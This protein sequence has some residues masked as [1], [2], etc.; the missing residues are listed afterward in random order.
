[1]TPRLG[2]S[3]R[4]PPRSARLGFALLALAA[5]APLACNPTSSSTG[6]AP[7]PTAL[8]IQAGA[9]GSGPNKAITMVPG[10]TVRIAYA[11]TDAFGNQVG[12]QPTFISRDLRIALVSTRGLI[13][14]NIPG[15]TYVAAFV[16]LTSTTYLGD[17]VKVTVSGGCTL[18]AKAGLVI[19]VQDSLTGSMG[20]FT[21][22]SYVA[23]DTS[24]YKDS[25]MIATV[26]A[27]VSGNTFLVG[28]AYEHPG[29]YDVT[30][31]AAG[32]RPWIKSGVVIATDTC[33]VIPVSLTARLVPQ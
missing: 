16:G 33:H 19:S 11:L 20:P 5:L 26:P 23:H 29:K 9:S 21:S 22:V 13:T 28:L 12:Y 4:T 25:T 17:S 32:Y 24:A 10:D 8:A 27:T 31:R 1:M 18:Q 3:H 6:S 30:V 7:P 14:G 15:T 2:E